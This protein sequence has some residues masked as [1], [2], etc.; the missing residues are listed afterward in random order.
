MEIQKIKDNKISIK[1]DINVSN[2]CRTYLITVT[3]L[4]TLLFI[5]KRTKK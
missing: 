3:I 5:L 1:Y 4:L 2:S